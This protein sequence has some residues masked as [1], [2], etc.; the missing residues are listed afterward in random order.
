V[1]DDLYLRIALQA[2]DLASSVVKNVG[3]SLQDLS[4]SGSMAGSGLLLAAGGAALVA[5]AIASTIK[6]AADFQ[7]Q[8]TSLVTGAGE[9]PKNL[10]MVGSGIQ[11][12]AIETGTA[13]KDLTSAMFMINSSGKIGAD[14]LNVLRAAAQG[15]KTDNA[16]LTT[17][18]K[19]LTTIMTDYHIPASNAV[20]A[21]NE[22]VAAAKAGKMHMQDL[23][24]SMGNVLPVAVKAGLSFAD[25]GGAIAMMTNAGMSAQRASMNLA[26]AIRSLS[27]PSGIAQKSMQAVGLSAQDLKDTLSTKGLPA[28]LQLIEEHIGKK[29]PAGSIEATTALKN[30]MGGAT[31]LNVALQVGGSNMEAYR[32]N[33]SSITAA[34]KAGG[35]SVEGWELVQQN[36][37]TR[38]QQAK[39]VVEVLKIKIGTALLPMVTS[40]MGALMPVVTG[41]S[42][43]ISWLDKAN[44]LVPILSGVLAGC[45][46]LILAVV[47]PALIG[48]AATLIGATLPFYLVAA[49]IAAVVAAFIY[50]YNNSKGFK[51][52]VDDS[53][54]SVQSFALSLE[55]N[56]K[57]AMK[58]AENTFHSLQNEAQLAMTAIGTVAEQQTLKAKASS[59]SNTIEQ[60][61][62]LIAHYQDQRAH[63]QS[64]MIFFHDAVTLNTLKAK[65]TAINNAEAQARGV[66]QASAWQRASVIDQLKQLD[67][68]TKL[69]MLQMKDTSINHSLAQ[70][71]GV[72][73]NLSRQRAGVI[74]EMHHAHTEGALEALEL[75]LKSIDHAKKQADGVVAAIN[76][77][78]NGVEQAM[79]QQNSIIQ[80]EA[81]VNG[82]IALW[83][84]LQSGT[85]SAIHAIMPVLLWLWSGMQ[86]LGSF[87]ATEFK[88]VWDE[89]VHVW[90][91]Q[92]IPAFS[93]L[94]PVV[95]PLM[96]LLGALAMVAGVILVVALGLL[97][98][99]ITGL[100]KG[101]AGLLIGLAQVLGGVIQFVGG[102][103]QFVSGILAFIVDLFTGQWDKLGADLLV[104]WYGILNMLGGIGN[105]IA[106]LFWAIVWTVWGILSGFVM[107]VIGF[108]IHLYNALVGH[109]IIPDMINGIIAWF[110][111]L[112][113]RVIGFVMFLVTGVLNYFR[114]LWAAAVVTVSATINN[115]VSF[116]QSLPG[117]IMGFL[118]GLPGQVMGIW[119]TVKTDAW[120]AGSNIVKSIGDGIRAAVHWVTDAVGWVG[121][122]I[123]DHLPH[124]PAKVGP[125]KDLAKQGQMI[126]EQISEGMLKGVPALDATINNQVLHSL[127]SPGLNTNVGSSFVGKSPASVGSSS[128]TVNNNTIN[129]TVNAPGRSR[130]EAQ[131]IADKVK[132]ELTKELNR[133]GVLVSW[134]SGGR[135]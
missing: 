28:A 109:S 21:T 66:V 77:Q 121:Q 17:V 7:S 39:E 70:S 33:V 55:N 81:V 103:V 60:K 5:G 100:A 104:A 47:V 91:A 29:F 42:N 58:T 107:G 54:G 135:T 87:I 24:G 120:N 57:P 106:G 126:T 101:F 52:I 32:K 3:R 25:V 97:V 105:L 133:S 75:R 19:A 9:L 67:P 63:I 38:M 129:V 50:F 78:K 72:V 68:A 46:A 113:G 44:L 95:E 51:A 56:L 22:L 31:G 123:R 79:Q 119:N 6:P 36:L 37:N 118:Q 18:T 35:K 86:L 90:Q 26:N 14:G 115:I 27:A 114:A 69:H 128:V 43:F 127:K 65:L 92:L 16:D 111:G 59:L 130:N 122:Q 83:Q 53:I 62:K 20:G 1:G 132:D 93:G 84:S 45:A 8:L 102:L 74:N 48:L 98:G 15:A 23:A 30:I 61:Q 134:A 12:I 11:D 80:N 131:D 49:A 73:K 85:V 99:I 4:G 96:M 82:A 125:L 41:F 13:T 124:S 110:A 10:K 40:I 88:P 76:R 34:L 112:P 117:R 71:E 108:F 89:L 116:W 64:E 94:Q 2:K